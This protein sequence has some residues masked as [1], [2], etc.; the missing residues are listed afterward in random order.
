MD[1]ALLR[2]VVAANRDPS[3]CAIDAL[4]DGTPRGERAWEQ[5]VR[6]LLEPVYLAAHDPA[7]RSGKSC[8]LVADQQ[9]WHVT[10]A[11]LA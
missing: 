3:L 1:Q 11:A 2:A 6:A 5:A 9:S 7:A 10:A 8:G 4:A